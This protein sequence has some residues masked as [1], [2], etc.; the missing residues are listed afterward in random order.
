MRHREPNVPRKVDLG[1]AIEH[2]RL[3][4]MRTTTILFIL[5]VGLGCAE[6][7]PKSTPSRDLLSRE[8]RVVALDGSPVERPTEEIS[9]QGEL[10]AA[11]T[12]VAAGS[13]AVV[14]ASGDGESFWLV[15]ME[16]F[17]AA[18]L[19]SLTLR[20]SAPSPGVFFVDLRF[21]D[22]RV[23]RRTLEYTATGAAQRMALLWPPAARL[24]ATRPVVLEIHTPAGIGGRFAISNLTLHRSRH[25]RRVLGRVDRQSRRC[26]ELEPDAAVE[27]EVVVPQDASLKFG[28]NLAVLAPE[29]AVQGLALRVEW[30]GADG[31]SRELL[32]I[33]L[34]RADIAD[35][36]SWQHARVDL[37]EL[38][39]Q[40]GTLRFSCAGERDE[41][42]TLLLSNPTLA[43]PADP[44]RPNVIILVIDSLRADGLGLY[45]NERNPSPNIDALANE[46]VVFDRAHSTAPWTLPST[47]TLFTGM[48]PDHHGVGMIRK[49]STTFR[50]NTQLVPEH[51][52][53][54]GYATAAVTDNRLIAADRGFSPGIDHFDERSLRGG[55]NHGG[56]R[57]T[58]LALQ[59]LERHSDE[60][61]F[62]YLHYFDPHWPYQAPAP[63]TE[64]YISP[65]MHEQMTNDLI[66]EGNLTKIRRSQ[67]RIDRAFNMTDPKSRL[68]VEYLRA[69]YDAETSYSDSEIGKVLDYLRTTDAW[70]N[71]LVLITADHGEEF[72]DHGWL[73][74]GHTMYEELLHIP[75]LIRFPD[76]TGAGER[77]DAPVSNQ[78]FAATVL[79]AS[80]LPMLS[81][82]GFSSF[83]LHDALRSGRL[84]SR[85]PLF[86]SGPG[87]DENK[88]L[89]GKHGPA[90]MMLQWP[91][92]L[93][94]S[95]DTQLLELYDLRI[96]PH[97][98]APDTPE[99]EPELIDEMLIRLD[100]ALRRPEGWE[101]GVTKMSPQLEAELRALGYVD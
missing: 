13:Q 49:R 14:D 32:G 56:G 75:L 84:E 48:L 5:L 52:K 77:I 39:G 10:H 41:L 47:A 60:N 58:R 101:E 4:I 95:L 59:W 6:E 31:R 15:D 29:S 82:E 22:S 36:R 62:L 67:G 64:K 90:Q 7:S 51:F 98:L 99:S 9:L 24:P 18:D 94:Y 37:M 20:L 19:D 68:S 86:A 34:D 80:G 79:G 30:I 65:Q 96:D 3:R 33:E 74:H 88:G 63:Y 66:R 72:G 44:E 35:E 61:F 2:H 27:W 73:G 91:Q 26:V 23:E 83:D 78:D 40:R 16:R 50:E 46:S 55:L 1:M 57:V 38:A 93:I 70:D 53:D 71:T 8:F 11:G 81:N 54:A 92:K 42:T 45:G 28:A 12:L 25:A 100:N 21:D 87:I 89:P 76:G 97:E 17:R 85:G 69:L 43:V